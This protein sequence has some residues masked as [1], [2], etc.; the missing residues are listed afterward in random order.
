VWLAGAQ[1][2]VYA[3]GTQHAGAV[4]RGD[5]GVP[6]E[7]AGTLGL[8]GDMKEM[9]PRWVRAVSL[10]G[11]GVSLSLGVG[12]PIPILNEEILK[13]TT[14]RDRDIQA[15]VVDYA[16][17]YPNRTGKILGRVTYEELRSGEITLNG[18]KIETGSLSSYHYAREI[19]EILKDEIK[20]G[21]FQ[22]SRPVR[23]LSRD[24]K[25]RPLVVKESERYG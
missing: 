14:V 9:D 2:M 6:V 16:T 3:E 8:T 12:I 4:E 24:R 19:A 22:V 7:G 10:A 18:K 15:S 1:G 23:A 17:D 11:Y 13:H 20:D 5:N 25:F 21:S